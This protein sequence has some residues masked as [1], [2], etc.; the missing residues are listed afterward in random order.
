MS[1]YLQRM[2][3]YQKEM[4]P[5]P[6]NLALAFLMCFSFYFLFGIINGIGQKGFS[7]ILMTGA[8]NIFLLTLILRLMD[9][10]K[11][12]DIDILLFRERSLPSGRVSEKD[13]RFSLYIAIAVF[14]II[15]ILY[16][17][18]FIFCLLLLGYSLMMY[19]FFF[20]P[21]LLR[22]HLLLSLITHN[23]V[24]AVLLFYLMILFS[25]ENSIKFS[26]INWGKNIILIF[27]FWSLI[28]AW[29]IS[30]K[31]R[32][33]EEENEYETYSQVF[34]RVGAA[35]VVIIIQTFTLAA[36]VYFYFHTSLSFIFIILTG[37][38][39]VYAMYG[40]I[41]FM[42]YPNPVTSKLKPFTVNY[43]LCFFAAVITEQ[44]FN[45][46]R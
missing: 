13:I 31:I 41:R 32:S 36:A 30:R 7:F 19:K 26:N 45:I 24:T 46:I 2:N 38:G 5:L 22:K 25:A 3:M 39:Y 10:L 44:I 4:F 29:E 16:Y 11:D 27:M 33:N 35:A 18:T 17:K 20:M 34:G 15:N 23:P 40:N 8:L 42:L 14:L 9:E 43:I 37:A 1:N 12:K 21:G 28:L 6:L